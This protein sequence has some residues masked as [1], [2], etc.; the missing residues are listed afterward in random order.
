MIRKFEEYY[1][2]DYQ[3]IDY[4]QAQKILSNHNVSGF[5]DYEI[6][7]I[8]DIISLDPDKS[9]SVKGSQYL[10]PILSRITIRKKESQ[11]TQ[12]THYYRIV[13]YKL[14]DEWFIID[15]DRFN[16]KKSTYYKCDQLE[17]VLNCLYELGF[18]K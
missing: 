5:T 11:I 18:K 1:K 16:D 3:L 10:S 14:D 12:S 9:Y 15:D 8:S 4:R 2:N 6:S 7:K 17:G 13:I